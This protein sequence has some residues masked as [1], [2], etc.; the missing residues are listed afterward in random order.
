[1]GHTDVEQQR[2]LAALEWADKG[3]DALARAPKDL[4]DEL[5]HAIDQLNATPN[6]D[7]DAAEAAA[8]LV[9]DLI[10]RVS[11]ASAASSRPSRAVSALEHNATRGLAD[12]PSNDARRLKLSIVGS[13]NAAEPIHLTEKTW[14]EIAGVLHNPK[15]RASKEDCRLFKLVTFGD[16]RNANGSLRHNANVEQVFGLIGDYDDEEVSVEQA[17]RRLQSGGIEALFYTTPSHEPE[18][19]RWRV[20]APLSRPHSPRDYGA[21]TD[22]LNGALGG[23]LANESWTLSQVF[24]FGR[25][26]GVPYESKRTRGRCIDLVEVQPIEKALHRAATKPCAPQ[27]EGNAELDRAVKLG[28]INED[29]MRDL[30]SAAMYLADKGVLDGYQTWWNRFGEAMTSLKGT[31]HEAEARQIFLAASAKT[32]KEKYEGEADEKW[33]EAPAAHTITYKA[34]FKDAQAAGW[35]NPKAVASD[36]RP[37]ITVGTLPLHEL[38]SRA[39]QALVS[40]CA[41]FYARGPRLV[42]P[43]REEDKA[44]DGARVTV[45]RLAPVSLPTM[46]DYLSRAIK[47]TRFDARSNTRRRCDPP[48]KVAQVL[49]AREGEWAFPPLAGVITTPT[50][51][52]DGSLLERAGYDPVTRL[53]LVDP[54]PLPQIR[55]TKDEAVR[56]AK[57]LEGLLSEFPFIDEASRATALSALITPNARGALEVAP[58][59]V[60]RAPAAGSGKSHLVDLA[61]VGATGQRCPVISAGANDEELEKR[62][63]AKLMT[64]QPLLSI[65]NVNGELGGDFLCQA[66]ERPVIEVRPLGRSE[67]VRI[68]SRTTLFAT[69]NNLAVR[70]DMT[71][72]TVLC[73][74]DANM[75]RPELRQ[76]KGDPIKTVLANRGQYVAA[77]LTIVRAYLEAGCPDARPMLA[78]FGAWSLLV[79]S[80]LTWLG[81]ADPVDTME[82]VYAEDP[83]MAALDQVVGAWAANIGAN[84]PLLAGEIVKVA[85]EGMDT[86]EA[87]PSLSE[88]LAAVARGKH[89]GVDPVALGKWLAR[90]EGRIVRGLRISS[91]RD[92]ASNQKRWALTGVAGVTGV[93]SAHF[94]KNGSDISTRGGGN[95]SRDSGDSGHAEEI[96]AESLV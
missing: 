78:S 23:I 83:E 79:R 15:E 75:E 14:G 88:A 81:Y 82:A 87:R 49:L 64:G 95:D 53:L 38:A 8:A 45:A 94:H 72:R 55:P 28:H 5:K 10:E 70:G 2:V 20:L 7:G 67:I 25:V 43:V 41:P 4:Q 76:F 35:K 21:L 36:E 93:F 69:G 27:P 12:E 19:P 40:A 57:F 89:G 33:G 48:N 80:A 62:L 96:D 52:P 46:L 60:N 90:R 85:N 34:V 73:S 58:I 50:L 71:R 92:G 61:A 39:E 59:H 66:I 32:G 3:R 24:Y 37:E 68:E 74:L 11:Q 91:T 42:R 6:G 22:R 30:G 54:L 86:D 9:Q 65:D 51:R 44:A 31:P 26:C 77:C 13:V 1:M 29:T 16:R 47:W 84:K 18:K 17:A 63:A 56:A